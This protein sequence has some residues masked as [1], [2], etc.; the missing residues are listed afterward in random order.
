MTKFNKIL[1]DDSS[2]DDNEDPL[3]ENVKIT[4]HDR[5]IP[6]REPEPEPQTQLQPQPTE[7]I[8]TETLDNIITDISN[9]SN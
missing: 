9:N 6:E 1:I 4:I 7:N 8:I 5:T 2:S 3:E